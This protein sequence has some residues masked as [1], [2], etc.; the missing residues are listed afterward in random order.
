MSAEHRPQHSGGELKPVTPTLWR[1]DGERPLGEA[2]VHHLHQQ[3]V[4]IG[5]VP[6]QRHGR[7][8]ELGGY[9]AH[10]DRGQSL[11]VGDR[12][13]RTDNPRGRKCPV[14]GA[15]SMGW[16]RWGGG[17]ARARHGRGA[18]T[19]WLAADIDDCADARHRTDQA[20]V[21][22]L[23][24]HFGGGRHR[25]A[26]LPGDL[27]GRG[28]PVARCQLARLDPLPQFGG[29]LAVA[30]RSLPVHRYLLR[31]SAPNRAPP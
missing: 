23:G 16:R 24:E 30:R 8:P 27:A 17:C 1:V 26:P 13:G 22:E 7:Y 31:T 2:C 19:Y 10:R 5:D 21:T 4:L 14:R 20:L 6:V 29:D 12:D 28:H 9:P 11:R 15:L 18:G 3:V 25:D